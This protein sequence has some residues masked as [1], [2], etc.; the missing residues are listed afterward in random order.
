MIDYIIL[1]AASFF[2][3]GLLGLQSKNVQHSRY[4]SAAITSMAISLANFVFVKSVAT[5]GF[6]MMV[7]GM[8]G[9]A[10]GIIVA[11]YA[12]DHHLMKGS[13]DEN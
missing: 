13:K 11:I 8:V 10:C 1:F 4:L 12:H 7:T 9:G 3:V 2:L 5:G 6:D